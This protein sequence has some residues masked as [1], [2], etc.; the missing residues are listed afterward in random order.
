MTH[1][2]VR[3]GRRLA[4]HGTCIGVPAQHNIAIAVERITNRPGVI[5]K[6]GQA[7]IRFP[8]AGQLHTDRPDPVF[9]EQPDDICP[10]PGSEETTMDQYGCYV[11]G[12]ATVH[13]SRP[14]MRMAEGVGMGGFLVKIV[15]ASSL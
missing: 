15:T 4:D 11:P 3:S 8:A 14:F 10:D 9:V 7:L 2:F 1:C 12:L 13:S 5:V 6:V